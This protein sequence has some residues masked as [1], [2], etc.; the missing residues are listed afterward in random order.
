MVATTF[1]TATDSLYEP[2]I[3]PFAA[4]VLIHNP[5][6]LVEVAVMGPARFAA[7]HDGAIA[8]LHAAFPARFR[9]AT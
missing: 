6:A 2:F 3:A 7:E 4:S 5:V 1:F 8:A 9:L